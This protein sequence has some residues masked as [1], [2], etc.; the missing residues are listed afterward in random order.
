MCARRRWDPHTDTLKRWRS[1]D[2]LH[3]QG[4]PPRGYDDDRSVWRANNRAVSRFGLCRARIISPGVFRF[5]SVSGSVVGHFRRVLEEQEENG[6]NITVWTC[7]ICFDCWL[8]TPAVDTVRIVCLCPGVDA[9]WRAT[10][11][12][13]SVEVA[14]SRRDRD[15]LRVIHVR[16][17]IKIDSLHTDNWS[18][19]KT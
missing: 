6:R 15:R 1:R 16:R 2:T 10:T 19:L 13:S 12:D 17:L 4:N 9:K 11:T 14:K 7:T 18:G 5:G 3:R 8:R